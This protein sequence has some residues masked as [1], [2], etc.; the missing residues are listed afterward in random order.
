MY[1]RAVH[2]GFGEG[3]KSSENKGHPASAFQ[4]W[5]SETV[6]SVDLWHANQVRH[7]GTMPLQ[8]LLAL[9]QGLK[10]AAV[11]GQLACS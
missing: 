3:L 1:L 6:Q 2:L 5:T 9:K 8:H 7:A 11:A 10:I 4:A